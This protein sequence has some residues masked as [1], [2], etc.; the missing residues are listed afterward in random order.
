MKNN[1]VSFD[2]AVIKSKAK[3]FGIPFDVVK[4][5]Y[6]ALKQEN[7]LDQ[8]DALLE[9]RRLVEGFATFNI[10]DV[11]FEIYFFDGNEDD[12]N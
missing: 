1:V 6:E 11:K 9:L 12:L 8:L 2:D 3:Q 4:L 7:K 10:D 5:D